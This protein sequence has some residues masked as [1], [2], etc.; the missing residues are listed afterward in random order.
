MRGMPEHSPAGGRRGALALS[1]RERGFLS[2]PWHPAA[3]VTFGEGCSE[4]PLVMRF[5]L[6][7]VNEMS[8]LLSVGGLLLSIPR[9][10]S[11]RTSA[12]GKR[13]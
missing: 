12:T 7:S 2:L 9:A 4:G 10:A 6:R 1:P 13:G 8:Q 5:I 3:G 11:D